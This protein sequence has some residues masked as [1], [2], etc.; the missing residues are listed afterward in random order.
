MPRK[1]QPVDVP[2]GG[3]YGRAKQLTESQEAVPRPDATAPSP[4]D[5]AAAY[6]AAGDFQMPSMP[7]LG[8]PSDRPGEA[9][10]QGLGTEMA[11]PAAGPDP[12]VMAMARYLP[13]FEQMSAQPNASATLRAFTLR[14]RS[15]LPPGFDYGDQ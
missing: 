11:G 9:V 2:T 14:L 7:G 6:Q 10:T 3:S 15:K 8:A 1:R 12:D 4:L 5:P 13:M